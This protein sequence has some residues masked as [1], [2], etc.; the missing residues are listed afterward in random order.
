MP[1]PVNTTRSAPGAPADLH[2]GQITDTSLE[3]RW[4][5]PGSNGYPLVGYLAS[6]ASDASASDDD[7]GG[8]TLWSAGDGSGLSLSPAG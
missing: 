6:Y 5:T 3:L 7:G 8:L 1:T 2:V 4:R